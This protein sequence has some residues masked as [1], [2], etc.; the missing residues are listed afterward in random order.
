M[1]VRVSVT[2]SSPT[3][4]ASQLAEYYF[5]PNSYSLVRQYNWCSF[6]ALQFTSYDSSEP[7]LDVFVPGYAA[8]FTNAQ[9]WPLAMAV[10]ATQKN[11]AQLTSLAQHIAFVLPSG[12]GGTAFYAVGTVGFWRCVRLGAF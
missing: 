5:D 11:V 8:N 10:G 1:V 6:G 4:T 12:L 2:D 7:V 9:L 3:F